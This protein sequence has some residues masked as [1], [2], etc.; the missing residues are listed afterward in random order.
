M[1][2]LTMIRKKTIVAYFMR[3][4]LF[5][6]VKGQEDLVLNGVSCKLAGTLKNGQS[7]TVEIPEDE[8]MVFIVFDK[9]FP[10]KFKTSYR[11]PAGNADFTLYTKAHFNPFKGNPHR[12]TVN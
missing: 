8:V 7:I 10:Q 3:A 6:E 12:I 4:F 9:L 2:K 5:V 1:R 11:I